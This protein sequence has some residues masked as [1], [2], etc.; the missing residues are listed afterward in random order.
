MTGYNETIR[1]KKASM[2]EDKT[3]Q[4]EVNGRAQRKSL[5]A[6]FPT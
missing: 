1:E 4:T 3:W 2:E 6:A 5:V